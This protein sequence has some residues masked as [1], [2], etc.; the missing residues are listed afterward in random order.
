MRSLGSSGLSITPIVF[1]AMGFGRS[2]PVERVRTLHAA[3]DAG[4]TSIDTA[5]L[6][7]FGESE[8]LVGQA[9][10]DRR[11]RVQILGKVGLRWDDEHGEV[12]F[13]TTRPD[14]GARVIRRDSRPVSVRRDVEQSLRRLGIDALDLCQVHHPDSLVP[15]ADTMGELS[16]LREEGKLRAIGVSNYSGAQV[17][18]AVAAL[19]DVPLASVQSEYSLLRRG[20]ERELLG[21]VRALGVGMLAYSPLLHGLLAGRMEGRRRLGLDDHRRWD[22]LFHPT[23]VARVEAAREESL[24]PLARRH[25]VSSAQMALAWLLHQPAVSGV[26]VGGSSPAQVRANAR[27]A[28]IVLR[29]GERDGLAAAFEAV[30]LDRDVRRRRRDRLVDRTERL[31][32]SVWQ[33]AERVLPWLPQWP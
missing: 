23:N 6:Y 18:E 11:D 5:P 2:A 25:G 28:E 17:L 14:G 27:A 32:E 33:R 19:G 12:L 7:G 4:I 16:R 13:T 31:L 30:H 20:V 24:E 3:I 21:V 9:I 29:A 10:A 8:R 15:I 22:P 26:I 1:G